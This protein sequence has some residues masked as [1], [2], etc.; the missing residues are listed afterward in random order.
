MSQIQMQCRRGML[1]L[2]FIF[3]KFLNQQYEKLSSNEKK[4]F[5]QLLNEED[6]TLYDWLITEIPCTDVALQEIV[7]RVRQ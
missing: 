2:D 1:E 4:L 5:S 7:K 6:P 3:E